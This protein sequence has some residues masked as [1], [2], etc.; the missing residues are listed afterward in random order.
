MNKK[1]LIE[2]YK[3]RITTEYN[4]SVVRR[5]LTAMDFEDMIEFVLIAALNGYKDGINTEHDD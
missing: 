5:V 2:A 3:S 4:R 1:K